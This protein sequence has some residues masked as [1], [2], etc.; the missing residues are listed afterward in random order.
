MKKLL[1]LIIFLTT[2]VGI[3]AQ[4]DPGTFS[5]TPKVGV[6]LANLSN[7]DLVVGTMS[8]KSKYKAGFITGVQGEYQITSLIGATIGAYYATLG[9]RY[10]DYEQ[11]ETKVVSAANIETHKS[12]HDNFTTLGYVLIPVMANIYIA[13]DFSLQ[14][15]VQA[16]IL[17]NAKTEYDIATV[18]INTQTGEHTSAGIVNYRNTSKD[19]YKTMDFSIPIGL[20][21]EYAN[22]VID[23]RYNFGLTNI[24][25]AG[26][27]NKNCSFT[28][29]VGYKFDL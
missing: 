19:G 5:L 12:Y 26:L 14:A 28:F 21:Y 27:K 3:K 8:L 15:G 13:K 7:N 2:V 16:G 11:V 17:T 18:T 9:N 6:S 22:V 20:S 29:A 23:A 24:S 4:R 25:D 10:D 1:V